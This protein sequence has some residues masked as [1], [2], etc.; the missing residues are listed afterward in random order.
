MAIE[1]KE[2]MGAVSENIIGEVSR[3]IKKG[4]AVNQP[5]YDGRTP[6]HI[7]ASNNNVEIA[8]ALL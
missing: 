4:C 2:I 8:R 7:A 3:L 1:A 5:D 6:L